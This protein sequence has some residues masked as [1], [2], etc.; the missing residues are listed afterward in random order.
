MSKELFR[1]PPTPVAITANSSA[2]ST[3][4]HIA[5]GVHGGGGIFIGN[6]GGATLIN[7]HTKWR[8]DQTPRQAYIQGTST[9]ETTPVVVGYHPIPDSCFAVPFVVPVITGGTTMAATFV[10]KG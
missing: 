9:A 2:A 3:A 8:E 6:T 1:N 5:Y 10:G 4:G 7:W